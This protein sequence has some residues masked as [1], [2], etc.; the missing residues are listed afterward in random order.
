[1]L[2]V[3]L[4]ALVVTAPSAD[5]EL[6][7]LELDGTGG[8]LVIAAPLPL[9][10]GSLSGTWDDVT[11]ELAGQ[12]TPFDPITIPAVPPVFPT[13]GSLTIGPSGT[14]NVTGTI[15]PAT[16]EAAL[17]A[18]MTM[19]IFIPAIDTTCT[20][21]AFDVTFTT[22]P[23]GQPLTP[24]PVD[25]LTLSSIGLEGTMTVPAFDL[26]T[27]CVPLAQI[28]AMINGPFGLPAQWEMSLSMQGGAVPP[29][30]STTSTTNTTEGTDPTTTIGGSRAATQPRFTG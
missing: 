20:T 16:G 15:D 28:A 2:A 21:A 18:T 25:H 30:S 12:T 1:V 23:P 13:Q 11:G 10:G 6:V 24:L 7:R 5:A 27:G 14:D 8:S 29:P 22:D 4:S 17:V 3:A 26:E 9:S 19:S